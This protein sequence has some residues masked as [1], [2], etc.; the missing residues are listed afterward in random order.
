MG[1]K[2]QRPES[3]KHK[4]KKITNQQ[5]RPVK[6]RQCTYSPLMHCLLL[7]V[8]INSGAVNHILTEEHSFKPCM[9][10][11]PKHGILLLL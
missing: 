9:H 4:V 8:P 11:L 1:F 10:K 3:A 5:E 7:L 6:S 2:W